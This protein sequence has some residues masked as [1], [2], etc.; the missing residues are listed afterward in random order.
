MQAQGDLSSVSHG[1]I[2]ATEPDALRHVRGDIVSGQGD[3]G[4]GVFAVN[5]G[6]L[7][8]MC[9]GAD[10]RGSK[11]VFVPMATVMHVVDTILKA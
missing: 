6:K 3:S 8:A 2:A 4:G 9:V 10:Q 7:I 1:R 5:S 11:A